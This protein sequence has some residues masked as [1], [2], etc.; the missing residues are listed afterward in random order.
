MEGENNKSESLGEN[1]KLQGE[2]SKSEGENDKLTNLPIP[3]RGRIVNQTISYFPL[4]KIA[5]F[6]PFLKR[7]K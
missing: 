6:L 5:V 1:G 2:N 7:F 4:A 3:P